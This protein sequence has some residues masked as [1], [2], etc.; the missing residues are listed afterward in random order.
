MLRTVQ[1]FGLVRS[2][3]EYVNIVVLPSLDGGVTDCEIEDFS[4]CSEA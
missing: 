4:R 1:Q 3:T 2:G